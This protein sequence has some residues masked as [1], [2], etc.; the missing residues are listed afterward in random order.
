MRTVS[1][2]LAIVCCGVVGIYVGAMATE[3]GVLVPFWQSLPPAEFLS[4]YAA[5]AQRLLDFFG[6]VTVAAVLVP[7]VSAVV[8]VRAG[9]PG[10]VYAV[11]TAALLCGLLALF[12]VYFEQANARFATGGVSIEAVPAEL[13]RWA[14]WHQLRTAVSAL[15]LVTAGVAV[16]RGR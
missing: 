15:A 4:W 6:P 16:R 11:V 13:A 14:W 9:H 2:V 10:R 1:D 5:N 12:F 7:L 8:A 3:A